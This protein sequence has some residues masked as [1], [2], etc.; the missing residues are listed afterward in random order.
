MRRIYLSFLGLGQ[1][2]KET[3]TYFY[4]RTTYELNGEKSTETP[5]VQT[6]EIELLDGERF[7]AVL[8]V[9][10]QKSHD[11]HFEKLAGQMRDLGVSPLLLIIDEE[12]GPEDQW[13]WFESIMDYIEHGDALT[14]DL[15]HGYRS[16]PIIFSAAINFLQKA[17]NISLDAVYYGAFDKNRK[18]A[19]IIDMKDFY[20]INEWADAVGRLVDDADA[21]KLAAVA[22]KSPGFQAGELNDKAVIDA[23][24]DLTGAIRNVDVNNV[25]PKANDAIRLIRKKEADAS[26]TGKLLLELVID[27]F[28]LLTTEV[29]PSGKYDEAY[30]EMQIKII[31]LLLEHKLF[32]QAYTVMREFIASLGMI[33]YEQE[34]MKNKKRKK[35][36]KIHAEVFIQM[37]QR[38]TSEWAF[39]DFKSEIS[40]RLRPFYET[41]TRI[42]IVDDIKTFIDELVAYRNGF[43][44]C[45]TAVSGAQ[46]D[47]P[48]KGSE[49]LG[50]LKI[51][52][53]KIS[54]NGVLN[55]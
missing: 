44:H 24:N 22:D 42:G 35:R 33:P 7:D 23:F 31:E 27:K 21:R 3:D 14:V 15:T 1:Y 12:M 30:F 40:E 36:R 50:K 52:L 25:V 54:E 49:F 51:I 5:F 46:G 19:P 41:L 48:E 29:P 9:A 38:D 10:T 39:S 26:R 28:T 43:D 37:V 8:I 2:D 17:R 18:L 13:R 32:M 20:L 55:Y 6:A 53:R 4:Q 47:I 11:M 34:G 16:I 45:W